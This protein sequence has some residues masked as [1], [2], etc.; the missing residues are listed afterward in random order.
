MSDAQR[1]QA[2]ADTIEVSMLIAR[3][4]HLADSG[5]PEEYIAYFTE[6]ATWELADATGL[7]MQTQRITGH[8]QIL[9]GVHERRAEGIQG[10][11][12]HT[13]HDV[14]SILVEIDGDRATSRTYFRYYTGSDATPTIVALG[15]Y[16]D[17]H[18]RTADGWRLSQRVITR[19]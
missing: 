14:S 8:A 16:N 2:A 5:T 6:D 9:A 15:R 1:L 18:T 13:R 11:G 12:T 19:G 7:P 3:I 10:P 17:V 4:A